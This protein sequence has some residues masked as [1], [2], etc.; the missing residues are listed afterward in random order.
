[1]RKGSSQKSVLN[2]SNLKPF[3]TIDKPFINIKTVLY[4]L[5]PSCMVTRNR[6]H[7][8]SNRSKSILAVI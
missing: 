1:M 6:S 7:T 4:C 8:S 3:Q 2:R 5:C